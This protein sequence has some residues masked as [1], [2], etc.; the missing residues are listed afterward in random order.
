[1]ELTLLV[2][3]TIQNAESRMKDNTLKRDLALSKST[4]KFSCRYASCA[5]KIWQTR[6]SQTFCSLA[7]SSR[8]KVFQTEKKKKSKIVTQ[9][10]ASMSATTTKNHRNSQTGTILMSQPH[11]F[12]EERMKG[13]ELLAVRKSQKIKMS[14]Q[15]E[16]RIHEQSCKTLIALKFV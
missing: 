3:V 14:D 12:D 7:A 1:M 4:R 13:I 5:Q 9:D 6:I 2:S 11:R 16:R 8:F 10:R 15:N